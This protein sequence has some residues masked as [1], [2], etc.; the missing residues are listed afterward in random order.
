MY[1]LKIHDSVPRAELSKFQTPVK[2]DEIFVNLAPEHRSEVIK[3]MLILKSYLAV[4]LQKS[5][6]ETMIREI[7][8]VEDLA[9]MLSL[10]SIL[11]KSKECL[12][13]KQGIYRRV[14]EEVVARLLEAK[15]EFDSREVGVIGSFL[16]GL[17][18]LDA[19][20]LE[21]IGNLFEKI[22]NI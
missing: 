1:E 7:V 19:T 21:L 10:F 11:I 15:G 12:A 5:L 6:M 8:K 16:F 18:V 9:A 13:D 22:K 17:P 2:V 20:V 4:E 3:S 14:M